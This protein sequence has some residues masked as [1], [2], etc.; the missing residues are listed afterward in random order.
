MERVLSIGVKEEML[1]VPVTPLNDNPVLNISVE[2]EPIAVFAAS[3][4]T[5]A[6]DRSSIAKSRL[7]PAAAVQDGAIV[8]QQTG[9]RWNAFGLATEGELKGAQLEQRDRG[10]HFA[11]AWLA[12]DPDADIMAIK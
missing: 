8:D 6:L 10:V 2:Q 5:S 9:S 4:A 11:F 3:T 12:F 7:I 1:L